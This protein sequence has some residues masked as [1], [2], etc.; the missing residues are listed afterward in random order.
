MKNL[1]SFIALFC[2]QVAFTQI[3]FGDQTSLYVGDGTIFF[4]GGSTSINGS[5]TNTGTIVS[6]GDFDFVL[7]TDVGN[8]KFTGAN[9]QSLSGDTLEVGDFVVDKQGKLTLLT[10]RIIVSGALQTTNGV[11]DAEDDDDLLVSGSSQALGSG[12]VEGKLV[13]ISRGGPVTFPMGVN[14][15]PNYMTISNLAAGSIVSVE[16]R[17]PDQNQLLPDEDMVGLSDEV[18]WILKV[19]GDST[20]A[21]ISVNFSG[22]DLNSFSNGEAIRANVYTPAIALF[23]K[24]DT[25]YHP[26]DGTQNTADP[27]NASGVITSDESIWITDDG[28]RLA[29]A[30]IPLVDEP[31]L[32]IPKAFAPNATLEENREFRAYFTGTLVT[33][34]SIALYDSFNKQ[35]FTVSQNGDD[36]DVS[37]FSWNGVLNSGLDAPE[38]VYYYNVRIVADSEEYTQVGSILLVK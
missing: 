23:S 36:L 22:V 13:G 27:F 9:D 25:L 38:G 11:I 2:A 5:L 29:I 8:L 35:V 17:V 20:T 30:L 1:L 14:G 32:Y 12:Y 37:Q 31:R 10:D 15:S 4:F 16:C 26:L 21:Q 7:N 34:I 19:K 33:S 18:E 28:R 6:Y 3:T 24:Q